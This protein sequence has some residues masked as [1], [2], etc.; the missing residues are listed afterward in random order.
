MSKSSQA[1]SNLR[2]VVIVIVLA[3]HACL[4]YVQSAPAPQRFDHPPFTWDA[5]P[6]VD[7]HRWLGFD[8][9][10]A[11]QDVSLMALMFFLSGLLAGP[12]LVRKGAGTYAIDRLRRIGLPF[13]FAL[14]VLSPLALY[15]AYALRTP[16]PNL[17]GYASAWFSLPYWPAG[18][19]WFLWQLMAINAIA[20]LLYALSP[21]VVR[22]FR[23]VGAWAGEHPLL[24]YIALSL[25]C[26]AGYTPLA[27]AY[28][29]F[30]WGEFGPFALQ[31]C[32]P[33]LYIAVFFAGFALG[34]YGL[35]RG[36]L[37]TDGPLAR[38][39]R[40]WT[41]L[42]IATFCIWAGLTSLTFPD[43]ETAPFAARLGAGLAYPPACIAGGTF[44]LAVFLRFSRTRTRV[45]DSLSTNAYGIYLV[46]Y[47]FIVW[48]QY[49]LVPA[50]LPSFVKAALVFTGA[51][52][53]SW[54]A[55]IL[56]TKILSGSFALAG[57]RPI[58]TLSR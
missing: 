11:W 43:W 35:E 58:W 21:N 48:L 20:A 51:F 44:M 50:D 5:F 55:S 6:I 7:A 42:A 4:A 19:Q 32:R 15:P 22:D 31:F 17:A 12:S 46:H 53:F 52:V 2:G 3:F 39:W 24:Y 8:I 49:A 13:V 36:L 38:H 30:T 29:P 23:R 10:C 26:I 37:S 33:L 18:P 14:V 25:I 57:K 56:V 41:A 34:S 54:P 47:V 16:D 9:F 28:S 27:A 40:T 45:L 1:L